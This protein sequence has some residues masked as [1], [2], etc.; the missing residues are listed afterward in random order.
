[1]PPPEVT[2]LLR[3]W[4]G[5]DEAALDRLLPVVYDELRRRAHRHVRRER[6]GPTLCTTALVHEAF[7]ALAADPPAALADRAHF[8]AVAS[9]V[10][11]RVLVWAARRRTAAKRGG[12]LPDLPL[13][14]SVW[15]AAP[16]LDEA[17]AV[18]A[19]LDRLE[20]L[21]PRL[22]RVVECRHFGGL[23]VDETA[24][25]LGVSAAT[26]KRDWQAARA[27]LRR[28]LADAPAAA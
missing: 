7:L 21:D 13:D 4:Q 15:L 8:Y 26:V 3:Q 1:M 14:P 24:A 23:S 5:G 18:D 6:D 16:R 2:L 11:R 20:R 22:C 25:A 28:E 19:A 9:R 27:W 10:M 17:L 12:G